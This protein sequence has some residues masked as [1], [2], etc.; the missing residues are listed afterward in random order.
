MLAGSVADDGILGYGSL[1][2]TQQSSAFCDD[3]QRR[4]DSGESLV[5]IGEDDLGM[6]GMCVITTTT[7][8]NCRHM[9][10]ASKAYLDPRVRRSSALIELVAAVCQRM[11]DEGV[12]HLRIDVRENSPAHRAWQRLGFRTYGI[13]DDY[14]RVDGVSHRGHFMTHSVDELSRVVTDEAVVR[15]DTTTLDH[16]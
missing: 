4:I 2:T 14:S 7:M 8:P 16:S 1:L 13:L 5:L 15:R 10:E 11:R 9:A 6:L 12:E 3:L